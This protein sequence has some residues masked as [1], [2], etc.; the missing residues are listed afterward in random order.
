[1]K[2]KTRNLI[3][4]LSIITALGGAL[5]FFQL[6]GSEIWYDE[7][8][9]IFYTKYFF[10]NLIFEGINSESFFKFLF[11]Y[12]KY[13]QPLPYYCILYFW[14]NFLGESAFWT[15]SLSVIF[16]TLSIPLIY[17]A[18][19]FFYNRKIGLL[20]ALLLAVSPFQIWLSREVRGYSF[21][22]FLSLLLFASFINYRKQG[23][24]SDWLLFILFAILSI[25]SNLLI[26]LIIMPLL[27]FEIIH[28]RKIPAGLSLAILTLF[29]VPF[30]TVVGPTLK[31][32]NTNFWLPV[33]DARAVF[34]N[35]GNFILGFTASAEQYFLGAFLAALL[36]FTGIKLSAK[37]RKLLLLLSLSLLPLAIIFVVSQIFPV[38]LHRQLI[39]FSPFIYILI[40][41]AVGIRPNRLRGITGAALF[42]LMSL[43]LINLYT[44][45]MP[46]GESF[47]PGVHPHKS[48]KPVIEMIR[49]TAKSDDIIA[50]SSP[51][52]IP[53]M[54]YYL[55]EHFHL[56]LY[57][58]EKVDP[59]LINA[60]NWNSKPVWP[61][62]S[63]LPKKMDLFFRQD[64]DKRF[65]KYPLSLSKAS[66]IIHFE[67][68]QLGNEHRLYS[69]RMWLLSSNWDESGNLS[70]HAQAV[71]EQMHQRFRKILGIRHDGMFLDLFMLDEPP[72]DSERN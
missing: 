30:I 60:Y 64:I 14:L 71:R 26:I 39:M 5:R 11:F 67:L 70:V 13:N 61:I 17:H 27:I 72:A 42:G 25:Y 57:I 69:G 41:A 3:G 7:A 65:D 43:S 16:G 47:H 32:L 10:Y 29:A 24:R 12:F 35:L 55:P 40:A 49:D 4:L 28:G 36:V 9:S 31:Y 66:G 62:I 46:T 23:R 33:P 15:R 59:Y 68:R 20:S 63:I 50:Y 6:S 37:N 21:V 53:S 48:L 38:F 44:D 18:G 54:A 8:L 56:F 51:D 19:R 52:T 34:L 45:T 58:P 22:L 2:L 1:M